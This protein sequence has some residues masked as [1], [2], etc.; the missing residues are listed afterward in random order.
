MASNSVKV[1]LK[2]RNDTAARWLS[3]NPTLASGEIGLENDTYLLKMGDGSTRWAALPYL[4]KLDSKF[5]SKKEDGTIVLNDEFEK[6][7]SDVI[8]KENDVTT[9][10]I[11][12]V[13]VLDTDAANKHYVDL[14][15]ASAGHLKREIVT[16]LPPIASVDSDT[17]YMI[18]DTTSTGSDKYKE[19]MLING[20]LEQIGDTSVNLNNLISSQ[21]PVAGH[22]VAIGANG[23]LIDSGFTPAAIGVEIPI[24]TETVI[25]GVLSS[26]D[27]NKISVNE[28]G[29]LTLNR[30]STSL[31]YVPDG[32]I[33]IIDGGLA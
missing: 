16:N 25:G 22:L 20:T 15:I 23:E 10:T 8:S 9:V 26:A 4:N 11:T 13:P 18:K 17:I 31:L 12:K 2:V 28:Q 29:F 7:I 5:F 21:D 33:F 3:V 14:A 24:A 1:T 32:D 19:Y 27:D 30:I 6:L